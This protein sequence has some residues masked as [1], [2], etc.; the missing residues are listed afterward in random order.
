MNILAIETSQA[1]GSV[2]VARDDEL[3]LEVPLDL[4]LRSARWLAPSLRQLLGQVAWEP[5]Q[6]DLVAVTVGPGSFT[7]LRVG[8]TTA[9][10]FAYAVEAEVLG[11]DTLEVIAQRAPPAILRLAVAVDAQRGQVVAGRFRRDPTGQ[12]V[13]EE[14]AGLRDCRAWLE[15]LPAGTWAAGPAFRALAGSVPGHVALLAPAFWDPTATGVA[16]VALGRWRAG[17]RDDLWGLSPRYFRRSAAEEKAERS[18]APK[19]E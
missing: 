3:L 4:A 13:A 19:S 6:V 18:P 11:V 17:Q 5:K 2:A 7:G 15:Q 12:F 10:S 14:P 1:A 8:V 16:R 9:K